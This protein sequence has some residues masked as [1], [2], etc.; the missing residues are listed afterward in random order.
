MNSWT[1]AVRYDTL[2][3][4]AGYQFQVPEYIIR[5]EDECLRGW[6]LRY[7]EW[8]FFEDHSPDKNGAEKSLQ[9]ATAEMKSRIEYKGK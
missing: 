5:V 3:T 2:I 7:G 1:Q 6:Q 8:T 4:P 9:L